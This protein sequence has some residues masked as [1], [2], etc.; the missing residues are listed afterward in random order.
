MN[1]KGGRA[2]GGSSAQVG[3]PRLRLLAISG[4]VITYCVF[5]HWSLGCT[6]VV[7][8]SAMMADAEWL[9]A[10]DCSCHSD[11]QLVGFPGTLCGPGPAYTVPEA[12]RP[13]NW[14]VT[15][16]PH[17]NQSVSLSRA[18][19]QLVE[20]AGPSGPGALAPPHADQPPGAC[21]L[22][23]MCSHARS[24]GEWELS[25]GRRASALVAAPLCCAQVSRTW[26]GEWCS[27]ARESPA[28]LAR[29]G[30]GR[31][32]GAPTFPPVPRIPRSAA[33]SSLP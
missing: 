14:P 18:R 32:G 12:V 4:C 10:L 15:A 21:M 5:T 31:W 23:F 26:R 30:A 13:H 17:H 1:V 6:R 8:R 2:R 20:A 3:Q 33:P 27:W 25:S 28:K 7:E 19:L 11:S 9:A 24:E 16:L 29:P 22:L